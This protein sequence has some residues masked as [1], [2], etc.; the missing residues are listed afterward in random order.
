MTKFTSV[1]LYEDYIFT[2]G[3]SKLESLT[4]LRTDINDLITRLLTYREYLDENTLSFLNEVATSN[5]I[6]NNIIPNNNVC[7]KSYN[8]QEII[9]DSIFDLQEKVKTFYNK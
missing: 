3:K 6:T 2:K 1:D 9:G 4:L 7:G 5:Y 8:N